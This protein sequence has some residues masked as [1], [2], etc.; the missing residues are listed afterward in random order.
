MT[1]GLHYQPQIEHI[2]D[3]GEDMSNE[4]KKYRVNFLVDATTFVVVEAA[5]EEHAKELAWEQVEN[6]CLCHQCSN[7]LDVGDAYEVSSVDEE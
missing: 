1:P 2:L 3:T 6:P 5:N 4:L 7:D